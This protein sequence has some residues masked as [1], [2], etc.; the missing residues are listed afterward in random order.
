MLAGLR[1]QT[2]SR[3]TLIILLATLI[4]AC[5]STEPSHDT[6]YT[7][8]GIEQAQN[9]PAIEQLQSRVLLLGDAGHSS[10]EP[11]QASLQ[12]AVER[13]EQAP[14]KT[15]TVMLGDNIYYF[16]F[17]NKEAGQTE[18]TEAQREEIR[19]LEAQLE[20]AKR[21]GSEMFVV[22]GNHDWYA[23][24]VDS[25]GEYITH[26]ASDNNLKA[27]FQPNKPGEAPVPTVAHRDGVSL[28][29]LDSM[30]LIKTN[31]AEFQDNMRDLNQLLQDTRAEYPDNLIIVTAHHPIETM[32]PHNRYYTSAAYKTFIYTVGMFGDNDQDT[33]YPTYRRLIDGI[34]LTLKRYQKVV[35]A[36]GHDHSLQVF[37]DPAGKAPEYRL[38]SGAANTSKLTGV[39]HND[40]TQF[41][42]SQEGLMEIDVYP[43]G[44]LL[45]VYTIDSNEPVFSQWLYKAD[46]E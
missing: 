27:S 44:V 35:Y 33:N 22:P 26:Y 25:M 36:A 21:S 31:E 39:G 24:Q 3:S 46:T 20:I 23:G 40:N 15:S 1:K 11:L 14:D 2:L 17:P 13:A 45:K 9:S 34:E 7:K 19:Y 37:K 18:F 5:V 29:F 38:V 28:I 41:A 42:Y 43:Q 8:P 6:P 32:G 10:F 30:W 12:K 4:S 16:G